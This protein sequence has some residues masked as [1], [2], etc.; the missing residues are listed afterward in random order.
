MFILLLLLLS[1]L[2]LLLSHSSPI[3]GI[4]T[5]PSTASPSY[6]SSSFSYFGASYVKFLESAGARV[7]PIPY[8]LEFEEMERIFRKIN[9]LLLPGGGSSL[10]IIENEVSKQ[11]FANVT[12]A[13][14]FLVQLA[15]EANN[16][17]DFFP[18]WGTCL[19]LEMMLMDISEEAGILDEFNSE[20]HHEDLL[21]VKGNS[22]MW[23]GLNEHLKNYAMLH[24]PAF[25]YHK[26]GKRYDR[27]VENKKLRGFF[28]VNT[29]SRDFDDVWFVSS[30]EGRKLPFYI[31]QFHPEIAVFEWK[32][33]V[34]A[35]HEEEAI[36][37]SQ[38]LGNFFVKE[39]RKNGHR[40]GM[41]EEEELLIY[42]YSSVKVE[43]FYE[44]VYFFKN[45]K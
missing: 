39:A 38:H 45:R 22:R 34:K 14:K 8:D 10:W 17:G 15:I 21:F 26:Y 43:E 5:L 12:L 9:G 20:N 4:L 41:G 1:F 35:N 44:Q 40:F 16:R 28:D 6:P 36:L 19:G 18:I 37:I 30:A 29:V 42:N 31:S 7:L 32:K 25:F 11:G 2:P 13:S 24:K 33:D 23:E 27:F 3:I